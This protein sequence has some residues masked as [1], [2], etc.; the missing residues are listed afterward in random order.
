MVHVANF[1]RIKNPMIMKSLTENTPKNEAIKFES[2][3]LHGLRG[4]AAVHLL[5]Y[6]SLLFSSWGFKTYGNVSTYAD[7]I[8]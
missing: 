1:H 2:S 8:F 3:A 7:M 6:H 4:F 5:I